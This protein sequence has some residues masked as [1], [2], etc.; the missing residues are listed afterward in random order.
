MYRLLTKLHQPLLFPDEPIHGMHAHGSVIRYGLL[1]FRFV[2]SGADINYGTL[3]EKG[4]I[5]DAGNI[6]F[7]C[8]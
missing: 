4:Q 5:D 7:S 8:G 6:S 1:R 3:D 2:L